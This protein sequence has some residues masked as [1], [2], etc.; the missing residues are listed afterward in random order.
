MKYAK[1]T[2]VALGILG[3]AIGGHVFGAYTVEKKIFPYPTVLEQAFAAVDVYLAG[4]APEDA[5]AEEEGRQDRPMADAVGL[6]PAMDFPA[7]RHL[8]E[9]PGD[10]GRQRVHQQQHREAPGRTRLRP[11]QA[12]S[13][14]FALGVPKGRLDL[15]PLAVAVEDLPGGRGG[16]C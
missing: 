13:M 14:V 5:K 8:F 2:A 15:H 6:I 10:V 4:P 16:S 7:G 1:Y 11:G 9:Q 12:E 3:L